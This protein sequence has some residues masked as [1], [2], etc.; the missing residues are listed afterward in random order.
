MEDTDYESELK[1]NK[2]INKKWCFQYDGPKCDYILNLDESLDTFFNGHF[3][4]ESV[5]ST[6]RNNKM[7]EPEW[8]T[9]N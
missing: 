9:K 7:P 2:Y 4:G 3:Y 8:P 1:I 5:N 6:F